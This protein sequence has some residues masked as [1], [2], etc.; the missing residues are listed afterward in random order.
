MNGNTENKITL[1]MDA[2]DTI[3]DSSKAIISILNQKY[4]ISPPKTVN[5]MMD[6]SYRSI[7]KHITPNEV[8]EI[9]SSDEF[10]EKVEVNKEFLRFYQQNREKFNIVVVT[11]GT[12][13]NI[14]K[15]KIYLESVFGDNFEYIGMVFKNDADGNT[16]MSY[17]K[18]SVNMR[19]GI[20]IDDRT[21]ALE[22]TNANIKILLKNDKDR[23]W[24][25]DY[26]NIKNLYVANNWSDV[27]E[28]L[29]FAYSN[30]YIFKKC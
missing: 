6:W 30:H 3:L 29:M 7:Y 15:K 9:Y 14:E 23:Y 27:I 11:K 2:D 26:E 24:N 22:Q 12:K 5:D 13:A 19:N 16:I 10:F 21:D 17:D 25:R 28:I 8:Q 4:A 20:Q 1:Y 18:S